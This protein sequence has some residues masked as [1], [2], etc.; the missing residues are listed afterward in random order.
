[1]TAKI[2]KSR[3]FPCPAGERC[4]EHQEL[5]LSIRNKDYSKALDLIS[6]KKQIRFLNIFDK[7]DPSVMDSIQPQKPTTSDAL[8]IRAGIFSASSRTYGESYIEPA[9]RKIFGV[10]KSGSSDFDAY[11]EKNNLKY[12]IKSAKVLSPKPKTEESVNSLFDTIAVQAQMGPMSRMISFNDRKTAQYSANIQNV[13]RDHFDS[14][15]YILI[16]EEGIEIFKVPKKKINQQSMPNWSD[17]HGRYDAL[18]K[19]GQF[20]VK[21]GNIGLHE[22]EYSSSFFTYEE[23][24]PFYKEIHEKSNN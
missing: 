18:G 9:I 22:K 10:Q 15:I 16:F 14:L 21:C 5:L 20:A 7:Q 8:L 3:T 6:A 13:K 11:D 24:V 19:S 4:P 12:E 1:M 23:L 2:C 17:K